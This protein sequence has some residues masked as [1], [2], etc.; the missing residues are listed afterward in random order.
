MG[1][2]KISALPWSSPQRICRWNFKEFW[3]VSGSAVIDESFPNQF[4]RA[5]FTNGV[6]AERGTSRSRHRWHRLVTHV[7]VHSDE[8]STTRHCSQ[9]NEC[10][11]RWKWRKCGDFGLY[12]SIV[13]QF[14]IGNLKSI[15]DQSIRLPQ[16]H[17]LKTSAQFSPFAVKT[18][19]IVDVEYLC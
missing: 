13:T 18:W 10:E 1:R 5:P 8:L 15:N 12:N 3:Q 16:T 19:E 7:S 6:A 2:Y 4:E 17:W 14:Q 11:L 9:A